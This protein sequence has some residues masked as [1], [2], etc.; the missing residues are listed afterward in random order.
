MGP[1]SVQTVPL[2]TQPVFSCNAMTTSSAREES[3]SVALYCTFFTHLFSV[4]LMVSLDTFVFFSEYSISNSRFAFVC[5][6]VLAIVL[7]NNKSS[8]TELLF[9]AW[10]AEVDRFFTLF[11]DVVTSKVDFVGISVT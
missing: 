9:D 8:S 11:T 2:Q 6:V 3:A 10:Y 4:H 5:I 1:R 7:S